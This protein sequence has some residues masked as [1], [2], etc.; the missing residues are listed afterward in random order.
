M[1]KCITKNRQVSYMK[2]A[3]FLEKYQNITNQV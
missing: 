2:P 3:D 1:C